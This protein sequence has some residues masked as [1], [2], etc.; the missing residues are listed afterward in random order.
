MDRFEIYNT[1][2]DEIVLECL[3]K[4]CGWDRVVDGGKLSD[5]IEQAENHRKFCK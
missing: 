4:R 5:I 2:N 1:T 3:I